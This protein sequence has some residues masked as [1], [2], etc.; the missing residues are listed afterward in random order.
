[1]DGVVILLA[2]GIELDLILID[3]VVGI[4][5]VFGQGDVLLA[6]TGMLQGDL[7]SGIRADGVGGG[8]R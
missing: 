2:V 5:L 1:M 3:P 4:Q 8:G 7:Q 6:Q